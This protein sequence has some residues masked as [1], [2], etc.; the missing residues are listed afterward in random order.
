M[1]EMEIAAKEAE[2]ER[3]REKDRLKFLG[4]KQ[5]S[6]SGGGGGGGSS[7]GGTSRAGSSPARHRSSSPPVYTD[8][9][10]TREEKRALKMDPALRP[11][12]L[13]GLRRAT[14]SPLSAGT[15]RGR[16]AGFRAMANKAAVVNGSA[17]ATGAAAAGMSARARILA[18][19]APLIKLNVNKR[20]MRTT[21]EVITDIEMRKNRTIVGEDAKE[22]DFFGKKK[23]EPTP[24]PP[25]PRKPAPP[26]AAAAS[27]ASN[28]PNATA[29]AKSNSSIPPPKSSKPAQGPATRPASR[30]APPLSRPQAPANKKR[31][32][33]PSLS[34][35]PEPEQRSKKPRSEG[36]GRPGS[37]GFNIWEI[38]TGKDRG[39][40]VEDVF[41]DEDDDFEASGDALRQEELR[42]MRIARMEDE[43]AEAE[44][45]RHE[46]EK[47]RR[48][49]EREREMERL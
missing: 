22:Y 23:T 43:A 18:A 17:P 5:S 45:R 34:P 12:T 10:L 8:T 44:E 13:A 36:R 2:A 31:P 28:K 32:R 38:V 21:A 7:G 41:S 49:K 26:P 37:H 9:F 3:R 27:S 4:V 25:P 29:S 47:R 30:P 16:Q 20:D 19:E 14:S 39:A 11:D 24:P 35:S 46:A 33:S 15:R 48:K 6:S 40:Y 42:S 1:K